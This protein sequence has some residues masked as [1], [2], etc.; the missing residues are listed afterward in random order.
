MSQE[1]LASSAICLLSP[2]FLHPNLISIWAGKIKREPII[3]NIF[4]GNLDS[5]FWTDDSWFSLFVRL[6]RFPRFQVKRV[7]NKEERRKWV[8]NQKSWPPPLCANRA[9]KRAFKKLLKVNDLPPPSRCSHVKEDC[10]H[11]ITSRRSTE[12]LFSEQGGYSLEAYASCM[13]SPSSSCA[14]VGTC[15]G[16]RRTWHQLPMMGVTINK[17]WRSCAQGPRR[18]G[19]EVGI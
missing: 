6:P 7:G 10:N 13:I 5:N 15:F 8:R 17:K 12:N 2:C 3:L 16:G 14:N 1:D 11:A 4:K 18:W 19:H 9:K